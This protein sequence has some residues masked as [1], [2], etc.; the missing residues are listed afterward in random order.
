[1][2]RKHAIRVQF[3]CIYEI[4]KV[5]SIHHIIVQYTLK[6]LYNKRRVSAGNEIVDRWDVVGAS[7]IGAAPTI[8]S[9]ST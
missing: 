4:F 6:P 5:I 8:S 9:F 7:P 3:R 1:M 2:L